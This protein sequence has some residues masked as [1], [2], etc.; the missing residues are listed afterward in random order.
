MILKVIIRNRK[1]KSMAEVKT[2]GNYWPPLQLECIKDSEN[3]FERFA[4]LYYNFLSEELDT[5]SI[6]KEVHKPFSSKVQG[7]QLIIDN[8]EILGYIRHNLDIVLKHLY[9]YDEFQTV[10]KNFSE[11]LITANELFMYPNLEMN[12]FFVLYLNKENKENI[13][14]E[15]SP[16]GLDIRYIFTF[17]DTKIDMPNDNYNFLTSFIS[18]DDNPIKRV[19]MMDIIVDRKSIG[20]KRTEMQITNLVS[21]NSVIENSNDKIL[22]SIIYN[23]V[24]NMIN[25]CFIDILDNYITKCALHDN[26]KIGDVINND[27][28]LWRSSTK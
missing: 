4:I 28:W 14:L 9:N 1:D 22:I 13:S 26:I 15:V 24:T 2:L 7:E 12:P 18:G 19:E 27:I 17:H 25:D 16:T 10:I 8:D 3:W 23:T 21:M 5:F 6:K 20:G 11:F